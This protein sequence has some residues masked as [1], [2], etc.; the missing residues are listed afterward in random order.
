MNSS[1][2]DATEMAGDRHGDLLLRGGV[3]VTVDDDSTVLDQ[4]TVAIRGDRIVAVGPDEGL[5]DWTADR[6]V[7][8]RGR[9]VMPG[10]VDGHNHLF[11]ALARGLGE[12]M[13]IW[14]WLCE[15]MW[16]YAISV[17]P[18][19]ALVAARLGV[20][21]ALRA[22]ITTVLDHHYAP[23]DAETVLAVADVIESSGMRGAVARGILGDKSEVAV[24]RGLPDAL[25]RYSSQDELAITAECMQERPRGST[26]EVWPGP[27]NLSYLDRD[28]FRS[29]VALAQ[30]RSTCWHTH[31]SEGQKDPAS[32][33]DAYGIRPVTWLDKEG[34]LDESATLAHA[35]WLN[36][37]EIA[38]A[39]GARAG[40]VHNPASNGYLA[41]GR[42]PLTE[43]RQAGARV[44]LGT[45]GPSC[46]HRQDLFEAMKQSLFLQ[47]VGTLDPTVMKAA[48]ALRLATREG[49]ELMGVEA[50]VLAPG[51]LA[52]VLV[53]ST[54]RPH[55]A[56]LLNP[57]AAAVYSVRSGDV[58]MTIC[59]GRIVVDHGRCVLVDEEAVMAEAQAAA[60]RL[61]ARVGLSGLRS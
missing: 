47:R 35:I 19:D 53:I 37:D 10:L 9:L 49:A 39:G 27:L 26:V 46:G 40:M 8:C 51:Y 38:A 4:A 2:P 43:L 5:S 58:D 41:S 23:T 42:M 33:L 22:G 61:V 21:E 48:D 24:K 30:E 13:S 18:E 11:Q 52:D 45:D 32:Y 6:V 36:D 1:A 54:D 14:P 50:G 57:V 28:M 44:G 29:S 34:M 60:E 25:F 20:I 55:L 17:G 16:P 3:V 15:F 31:C 7:D 59:G 56:P 12:G